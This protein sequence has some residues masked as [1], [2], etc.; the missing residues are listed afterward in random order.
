VYKCIVNVPVRIC[1]NF[2]WNYS[3]ARIAVLR[4]KYFPMKPGKNVRNA[5]KWFYANKCL[6]VSHGALLPGSAWAKLTGNAEKE[7]SASKSDED[8]GKP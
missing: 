4:W 3:N 8:K 2:G 6:H 1:V 5:A 7:P